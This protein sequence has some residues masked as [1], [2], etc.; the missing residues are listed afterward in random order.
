MDNN[1]YIAFIRKLLRKNKE[2][3]VEWKYL[4]SNLQ[5]CQGMHW[6]ENNAF[7]TMA[8]VVAG[9]DAHYFD[10]NVESSFYCKISD[11]YVVLYVQDNNPAVML[12]IPPTFKSVL[13]LTPDEYGEYI[14]RL[15]NLVQSKFPTAD[16]FIDQFLRDYKYE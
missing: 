1:K 9:K 8:S 16:A 13:Q 15:L 5:L 6:T 4:D 7:T 14:T 3:T 12:I 10:F 2:G 11:Y